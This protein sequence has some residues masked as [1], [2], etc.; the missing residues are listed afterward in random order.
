M[1]IRELVI[2][3]VVSVSVS[4]APVH[5]SLLFAERIT[6][7]FCGQRSCPSPCE[8]SLQHLSLT[9]HTWSL[10]GCV[11]SREALG[12]GFFLVQITPLPALS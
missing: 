10:G 1:V 3:E 6:W 5:S 11:V 9:P 12:S 4:S 2:S 7:P 8:S